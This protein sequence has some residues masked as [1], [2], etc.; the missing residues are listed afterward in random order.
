MEQLSARNAF[1]FHR[2][3]SALKGSPHRIEVAVTDSAVSTIRPQRAIQIDIT[4][5]LN[6]HNAQ[7]KKMPS[8]STGLEQLTASTRTNVVLQ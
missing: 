4:G 7:G 2:T 1:I 6:A 5:I 3:G 8:Q